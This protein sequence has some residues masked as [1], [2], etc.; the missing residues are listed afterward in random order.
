ML[1]CVDRLKHLFASQSKGFV[2]PK[3]LVKETVFSVSEIEALYEL[4]KNI[5]NVVID[6]RLINKKF[7][8]ALF[9]T[10]K[11]KSLFANWM[12]DM[13]DTKHNGILGFE[14]FAR[15]LSIFHP[16]ALIDDKNNCMC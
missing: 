3:L 15:A 4:F 14:E 12:L 1:Q 13:L 11:K 8:L 2:N 7:Q 9:K 5:S 16:N 6:D 10:N